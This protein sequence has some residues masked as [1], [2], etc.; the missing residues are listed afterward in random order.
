MTADA[1]LPQG[2]LVI[3]LDGANDLADEKVVDLLVRGFTDQCLSVFQ[4][5]AEGERDLD[6][7]VADIGFQAETLNALFLGFSPIDAVI[8]HPWNSPDQLG[9]YLRE[10]LGL[11]FPN[12]QCVKAAFVHV[13]TLLMQ[14]L[15]HAPDSWEQEAEELRADLCELLL[16]R[17]ALGGENGDLTLPGL[18]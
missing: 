2:V 11:D 6:L 10:A 1:P 17:V 15:Q 5:V 16:G 13:A 12:D 3:G 8:L 4:S 9:A 14:S 7:A 18:E